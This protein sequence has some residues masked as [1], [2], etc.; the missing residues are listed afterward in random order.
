MPDVL[1][2]SDAT[3]RIDREQAYHDEL[4][5]TGARDHLGRYYFGALSGFRDYRVALDAIAAARPGARVLEYGCGAGSAAFDLSA[6]GCQVLGIDISPAAIADAAATAG[7]RG[8]TGVTFE[9]MDAHRLDVPDASFDVVCGT[10]ILHHLDLA[11]ALSEVARVLR[12]GG[13][14]VFFE[15]LGHNPL[16]A[17]YR[18][19]TPS[20]RTV[21]ERP[22]RWS[23]LEGARRWFGSVETEFFN[24]AALAVAPVVDRPGARRAAAVLDAVDRTLFRAIPYL[25]R[26]AWTTVIRLSDPRPGT[27]ASPAP[28]PRRAPAWA[29]RRQ[30]VGVGSGAGGWRGRRPSA[31][32]G[33][34]PRRPGIG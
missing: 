16:L 31:G 9:V 11:V 17:L 4:S 20:L 23:D 25:R 15:P 18:R 34:R 8:S 1:A 2:R 22:L 21:D 6:L 7:E 29:G 24:L 3:T 32:A 12:P 28:T 26:H 19:A 13:E 14:A 5:S 10:A 30:G 33:A 27:S